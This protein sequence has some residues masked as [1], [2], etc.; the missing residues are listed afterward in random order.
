MRRRYTIGFP[1]RSSGAL[2][3]VVFV[4]LAGLRVHIGFDKLRGLLDLLDEALDAG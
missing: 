2:R 3:R 1:R 4:K